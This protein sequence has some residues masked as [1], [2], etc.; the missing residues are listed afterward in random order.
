MH[1]TL[2][3]F[4]IIFIII[5]ATGCGRSDHQINLFFNP[6][7]AFFLDRITV[8]VKIDNRIILDTLIENRHVDFSLFLKNVHYRPEKNELLHVE[9][10]GK[11][12]DVLRMSGLSGC[13][14]IFFG[15]DD[16]SLIFEAVEKIEM[17][18]STALI[19]AD[20]RKLFDS[21]RI[22][23]GKRFH[24]IS[25]NIKEGECDRKTG[26]VGGF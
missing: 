21:I 10:N 26:R 14:D 6:A 17:K 7:G 23:S 24:E 18:R 19:P 2:R 11:K 25:F 4:A 22:A 8:K 15:Y 20:S 16:H 13:T 3:P 1:L 5:C 9:I 12:K